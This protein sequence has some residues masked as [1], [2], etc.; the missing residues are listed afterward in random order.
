MFAAGRGFLDTVAPS[1]VSRTND[2]IRSALR[3][4][5]TIL[6]EIRETKDL[7]DALQTK[8]SSFLEGLM[9]KIAPAATTA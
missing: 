1:D 2:E 5:G 7:P 4:E 6:T 9:K 8:L 3:D